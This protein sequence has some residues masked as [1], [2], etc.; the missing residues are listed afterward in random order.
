MQNDSNQLDLEN[1]IHMLDDATECYKFYWFDAILSMMSEGEYEIEFDRIIDQMI[2]DAWYSVSE[3]HLHLGLKDGTGKIMNSLERAVNKLIV[4]SE[5][6]HEANRDKIMAEIKR[7]NQLIRDEKYQISKMV[8]YRLLSPFLTEIGGNHQLW[9]QKKRLIA[10]IKE[11]NEE[12]PLPYIIEDAIALKKRVVIGEAWRQMLLDYMV[13]IKSWI[14][15]KKIKYLQDRNPGIPGIIY[16][17]EPENER[18][19]KLAHV[20]KLWS[21]IM[22]LS[23]V[24]D[25]YSDHMISPKEY[26]VDHFIP[27]SYIAHDEIWNL[28][29]MESSLNS[30]KGNRLP[31][32]EIYFRKFAERQYGMY[33]QVQQSDMLFRLFQECHR[34]NLVSIWASEELYQPGISEE[35]FMNILNSNMRPIYDSAHVQ[36]YGVWNCLTCTKISEN[37]VAISTKGGPPCH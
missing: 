22:E 13:P 12:N 27:W 3:Y 7:Q 15:L 6:D 30:S 18:T 1:F 28:I 25:I 23:P 36:G 17:L 29:P 32:W 33:H 5:L 2:A 37:S 8:P 14:K 16:K 20:R 34:D 19:R 4:H 10:Y 35:K 9:G 24:R 21:S 31:R 26:E 11:M